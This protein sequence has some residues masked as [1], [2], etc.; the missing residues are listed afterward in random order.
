MIKY[1]KNIIKALIPFYRAYQK[2][3]S[4]PI[5]NQPYQNYIKFRLTG[6]CGFGGVLSSSFYLYHS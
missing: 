6:S 3:A 2:S 1:I 5:H 4:S